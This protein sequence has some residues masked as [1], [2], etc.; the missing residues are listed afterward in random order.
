M[1]LFF[2]RRFQSVL[3]SSVFKKISINIWGKRKNNDDWVIFNYLEFV[4]ET[5]S[6]LRIN[7]L[8][9]DSVDLLD[10]FQ[11]VVWSI[12]ACKCNHIQNSHNESINFETVHF[13]AAMCAFV[14]WMLGFKMMH[15]NLLERQTVYK[16]NFD[17]Y[18]IGHRN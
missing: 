16:L 14:C 11:N 9:N 5:L 4:H 17:Y 8:G 2:F 12:V 6:R 18:Y 10:V 7:W 13:A 3:I 15:Y 1:W